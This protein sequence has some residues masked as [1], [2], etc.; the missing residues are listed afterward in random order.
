MIRF[1]RLQ[2][3]Q[4]LMSLGVILL[5]ALA[6]VSWWA[7]QGLQPVQPGSSEEIEIVIPKG[8]SVKAI[9]EQLA[10]EGLI[11]SPIHFQLIV[12]Q[13]GL[14]NQIQAG[15]FSLSPGLS[16]DEIA[17]QLT[18]GTNDVWITIKEGWRAAEIGEYVASV[19]PQFDT[20]GE[21]FAQECLAYEG[22]LYPETYL[23][24]KEYDTKQVCQLLRRQYGTVV[25]MEMREAIHSAGYTEEEIITLASIVE[26][27]AKRP[28]D[29]KIVAGI[30]LNRLELGMPLQVDATLQYIKG[31]NESTQTWWP[32]P[33]AADKQLDSPYNTYQNP[34]LPPGPISN[35]GLNAISAA[36]YPTPS[37]YLYYISN[38]AGT[39]MHYAQTY[40][41]HQANIEQY[42]R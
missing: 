15:S 10:N 16:T 9:S 3:K 11:R 12:Q 37:D 24:P 25:T 39:Q 36:I 8:S 2:P 1:T 38:S 33:L 40:E 28:A 34:G 23:V 13:K 26:R 7:W 32:T 5:L 35:P 30:L 31:Y 14:A 20:T 19:L 29:M 21:V 6:G 4:V 17:T 22:F 41:Q 18:Q 42:L 27:E